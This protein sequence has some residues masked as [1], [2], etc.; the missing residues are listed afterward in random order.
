[1]A[2]LLRGETV[3]HH[4]RFLALRDSRLDDIPAE[5][6]GRVRLV[7][8]AATRRCSGPR[9]G[10]PMSSGSAALARR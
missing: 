4:G 7:I 8:G 2:R 1:M 10:M 6:A 3:T 9:P 5:D